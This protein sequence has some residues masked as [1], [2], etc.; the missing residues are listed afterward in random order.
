MPPRRA[1][2]AL[3]ALALAAAPALAQFG[4]RRGGG[5]GNR[6][7]GADREASEATRMDPGDQVRMQ[8][9]Q[10]RATLKLSPEQAPLWQAYEDRLL[11]LLDDLSRGFSA[12]PGEGALKQIDRRVDVARN[13]LAALED[14]SDA[15]RRLYGGLSAEQQQTAD[16][17]LP[18]TLPAL[19]G[20]PAGTRGGRPPRER[21]RTP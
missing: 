8:I 1:L 16:R 9:A 2:L 13:R 5:D 3:P 18:G 15:A 12:P 6:R 19:Y 20:A 21:E 11:A 14:I 10:V 17:M 4:G 7:G